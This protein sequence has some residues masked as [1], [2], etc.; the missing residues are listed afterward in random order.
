M[1][2]FLQ[3]AQSKAQG[4]VVTAE[5]VR[6]WMESGKKYLLI[7]ARSRDEYREAHIPGALNIQPES[8]RQS[9]GRLPK[10]RSTPIIFYC[11]GIG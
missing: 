9:K 2:V 7:D 4:L 5:E 11:R 3:S 6:G 8:M 10:D 1:L